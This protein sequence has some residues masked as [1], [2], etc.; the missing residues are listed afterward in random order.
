[1][2]NVFFDLMV[3]HYAPAVQDIIQMVPLRI[4]MTALFNDW[5]FFPLPL[6]IK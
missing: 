1:M 5:K 2:L 3:I 6:T 4:Y